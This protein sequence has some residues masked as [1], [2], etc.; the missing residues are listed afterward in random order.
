MNTIILNIAEKI[1]SRRKELNMSQDEL[2]RRAQLSR[3]YVNKLENARLENITVMNLVRIA[4]ALK[5]QIWDFFI[6][7]VNNILQLYNPKGNYNNNN[8][9]IKKHICKK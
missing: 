1:K 9:L 3:I 8:D 6:P 5:I 7:N 2:A 4:E